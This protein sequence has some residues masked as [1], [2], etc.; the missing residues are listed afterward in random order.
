[1]QIAKHWE[2]GEAKKITHDF[3]R[4]GQARPFPAP[5]WKLHLTSPRAKGKRHASGVPCV[6][7][8]FAPAVLHVNREFGIKAKPEATIAVLLRRSFNETQVKKT[9]QAVQGEIGEGSKHTLPRSETTPRGH[10]SPM[11]LRWA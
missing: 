3:W 1:M 5:P 2:E 11:T 10:L 7:D 6:G 9:L 8:E 4:P